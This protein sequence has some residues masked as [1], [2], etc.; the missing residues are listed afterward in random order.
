[1]KVNF[2]M[3]NIMMIM[4]NI[5]MKKDI[6]I[7]GNLKKEKRMVNLKEVKMVKK[8]NVNL[9]MMNLQIIIKMKMI[10]DNLIFGK[11]LVAL[12]SII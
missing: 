7:K 9:K 1:M 12:L 2:Q 5:Q 3:M 10:M 4:V 11:N 8:L 6:L